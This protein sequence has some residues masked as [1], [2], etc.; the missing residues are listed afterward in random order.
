M[1][2]IV[3]GLG[4]SSFALPASSFWTAK[5][6]TLAVLTA[7]AVGGSVLSAK[8]QR[9]DLKEARDRQA[10][11]GYFRDTP[12]SDPVLVALG[13]TIIPAQ[14][15]DWS[16]QGVITDAMNQLHALGDVQF[17]RQ[18]IQTE[19][20]TRTN[21]PITSRWVGGENQGQRRHVAGRNNTVFGALIGAGAGPARTYNCVP[22]SLSGGD[23]GRISQFRVNGDD[24]RVTGD[25]FDFDKDRPSLIG[26]VLVA[27]GTP[28]EVFGPARTF[29]GKFR[30]H[31]FTGY[32]QAYLFG[33][34]EKFNPQFGTAY[35]PSS[36]E[37]LTV[38]AG[39][40]NKRAIT[41]NGLGGP[42][43]SYDIVTVF[44]NVAL[45]PT[46]DYGITADDINWP[47]AHKA[48]QIA[49][50]AVPGQTTTDVTPIPGEVVR[51]EGYR[52]G[53]YGTLHGNLNL[54]DNLV[55]EGSESHRD[56]VTRDLQRYEL[57]GNFSTEETL[58][59]LWRKMSEVAPGSALETDLDGK[60]FITVP[61][62]ETPA[63]D[64]VVDTLTDDDIIGSI[65]IT[66]TDAL[67]NK[68]RGV[69]K[70]AA[71]NYGREE[72]VWP[73]S[74]SPAER[75][76][77]TQDGRLDPED[78][79]FSYINNEQHAYTAL[80][81]SVLISRR[82]V[83]TFAA[84][85]RV[86]PRLR[87]ETIAIRSKTQPTANGEWQ[88]LVKGVDSETG[89]FRV[90]AFRYIET[91]FGW[92]LNPKDEVVPIQI[93]RAILPKPENVVL[94]TVPDNDSLLQLAF[95]IDLEDAT[96]I[97]LF[98]IELSLDQGTTWS[99]LKTVGARA[100]SDLLELTATQGVYQVR[101][102]TIG[103]TGNWS[104]WGE[105]NILNVNPLDRP[106][107]S[108]PTFDEERHVNLSWDNA[109][110]RNDI[111]VRN[112]EE[113]EWRPLIIVPGEE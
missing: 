42:S 82:E 97:R 83:A 53:T 3:G 24:I 30:N 13:D 6:I 101:V 71:K 32:S 72:R 69:Y 87:G 99:P 74:G 59:E 84:T 33:K 2:I 93:T 77:L 102:R 109:G 46:L 67:H 16:Q 86:L 65:Q 78:Y 48:A 56:P 18:D 14:S 107:M 52:G 104:G 36:V 34:Q 50:R 12:S 28:G 31:K 35:L 111:Q 29:D 55:E 61:D 44:I 51:Q 40:F 11:V 10:E 85:A 1:A 4:L 95:T 21:D 66:Q 70:S 62:S 9:A 112:S 43:S 79:R 98:E 27:L 94:R 73:P 57:N 49:A 54:P 39:P 105:S 7:S 88:I 103:E 17:Y 20:I 76:F 15:V 60:L 63:A 25:S 90:S 41:P 100:R 92:R 91:D 81:S 96:P 8:R 68:A 80:A 23:I 19:V 26:F 22:L 89:F 47:Q 38:G 108:P 45:D 106:V 113:E 64:Q 37:T 58:I 110:F 75:E 5:T